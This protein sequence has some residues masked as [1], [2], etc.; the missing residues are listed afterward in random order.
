MELRSLD[1][2][3]ITSQA[4]AAG[5]ASVEL[6]VQS[7]IERDAE[8]LAILEGLEAAKKGRVRPFEE[9][10]REFRQRNGLAP[11]GT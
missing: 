1:P 8:R 2:Q 5:F 11:R 9:F 10:D 6:Y 4:A 7:L 3:A